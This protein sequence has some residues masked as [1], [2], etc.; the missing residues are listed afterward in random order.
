MNQQ[1]LALF[2]LI[3]AGLTLPAYYVYVRRPRDVEGGIKRYFTASSILF[4]LCTIGFA[5]MFA[6][7]YGLLIFGIGA[8]LWL[9][10]GILKKERSG[11]MFI[12]HETKRKLLFL[13][14]LVSGITY[15]VVTVFY[16][17][18]IKD[19]TTLSLDPEEIT[20]SF[21]FSLLF[22]I[23]TAINIIPLFDLYDARNKRNMQLWMLVFVLGASV[24]FCIFQYYLTV[25][26]GAMDVFSSILFASMREPILTMSIGI[27]IFGALLK[28]LNYWQAGVLGNI[29]ISW[30][31]SLI[32]SMIF[33]GVYSVPR[34]L[35]TLFTGFAFFGWFVYLLIMAIVFIVIIAVVSLFTGLTE[36]ISL[37]GR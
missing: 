37:G 17:S 5:L 18:F 32:W 11:S 35:T 27:M 6:G 21:E 1:T 3:G 36:K 22:L 10:L 23:F 33:V 15:I 2:L 19:W 25:Y 4:F 16:S 28:T 7:G 8:C 26:G 34:E 13:G 12:L 24:I 29:F 14:A 30:Y 31:P 20:P 9:L